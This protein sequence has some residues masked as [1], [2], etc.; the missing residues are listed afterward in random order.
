MV[1]TVK[2]KREYHRN[3]RKKNKDKMKA[4]D[5]KFRNS[6]KRKEY[7]KEYRK[8]DKAKDYKKKWEDKNIDK[9]LEYQR[10]YNRSEKG[11][12]KNKKYYYTS[13]GKANMLRKHDAKRLGV[14]DHTLTWEIIE[15]VDARDK[16]CVYCGCK[17]DNN[18]E[19]DHINAFLKFS[20][21]NIVRACSNC[22]KEKCNANMIEWMNFKGH[23]ISK[24][25]LD[26]YKKSRK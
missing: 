21:N 10:K 13:K 6:D 9:Q 22:N 11:K 25:L 24:K 16:E 14:K 12:Q 8:T 26:L 2:E 1:K 19:Y 15:M 3:Y 20:L 4:A 5:E 18:I 23:K 17:L 7:L